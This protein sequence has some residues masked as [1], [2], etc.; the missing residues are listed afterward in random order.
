M[1][2][3]K[4]NLLRDTGTSAACSTPRI[5]RQL[6]TELRKGKPTSVKRRELRP[7][8]YESVLGTCVYHYM[9]HIR[10]HIV[11]VLIIVQLVH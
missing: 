8:K 11:I 7:V 9:F 10:A 1:T 6:D 4:P 3:E 5:A 2:E